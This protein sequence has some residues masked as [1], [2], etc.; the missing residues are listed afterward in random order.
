M[1][2][3]EQGTNPSVSLEDLEANVVSLRAQLAA[4]EQVLEEAKAAAEGSSD[5]SDG[6]S[7]SD[8][9]DTAAEGESESD[10]GDTAAEGEAKS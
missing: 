6:E 8:G 2:Q 5:D 10:G 4:A 9:G 7:E 1:E 3:V